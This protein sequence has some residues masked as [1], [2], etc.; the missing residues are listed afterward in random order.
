MTNMTRK[1]YEEMKQQYTDAMNHAV[2]M[3][4]DCFVSRYSP[5]IKI[6]DAD[7]AQLQQDINLVKEPYIR[8]LIWIEQKN[9]NLY[10]DIVKFPY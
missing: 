8:A 2:Q 9:V 7:I 5:N 6:P 4:I 1:E 3:E 10:I